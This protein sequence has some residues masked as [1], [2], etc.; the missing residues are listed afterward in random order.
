[1]FSNSILQIMSAHA[2]RSSLRRSLTYERWNADTTH[3]TIPTYLLNLLGSLTRLAWMHCRRSPNPPIRTRSGEKNPSR[4][5]GAIPILAGQVAI[6]SAALTRA[7]I[8]D[9]DI[10]ISTPLVTQSPTP[11]NST[12]PDPVCDSPSTQREGLVQGQTLPTTQPA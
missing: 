8:V 11:S 1:M 7:R 4:R 12:A 3:F 9:G 10:F 2:Q 6:C 5:L